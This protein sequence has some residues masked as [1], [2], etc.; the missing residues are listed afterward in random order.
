MAPQLGPSGKCLGFDEKWV[1][2]RTG[3]LLFLWAEVSVE[4][5]NWTYV[6]S[7][8]VQIFTSLS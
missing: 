8:K 7:S 6:V 1:Q 2:F 4:S 5:K 3:R